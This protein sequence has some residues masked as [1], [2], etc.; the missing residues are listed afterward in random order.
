MKL[1]S[2]L[3]LFY[4]LTS[5]LFAQAVTDPYKNIKY[6]ELNNGLKVYMLSDEKAVNTQIDLEVNVGT[7]VETKENAGITHLLEH[8]IF[9][10]Q[11]VPY[12]DYLD[13]LKEE[14][15]GFVNGYTKEYSTEYIATMDSE[16]SYFL[17]KTL[18]QMI[19]D[20]NVT[21]ED[22]E[23]EKGAIQVE[24]GEV[25]WYH[26]IDYYISSFF[27]SLSSY[28]PDDPDVFVDSF[29]LEK[30][31]ESIPEYISKY[32]NSKFT[33]DEVMKH[34]EEYYYPKNMTLKIVGNF[35][36]DKMQK[37]IEEEYAN[38][39]RSGDKHSQEQAYNA[40]LKEE[41]YHFQLTG[42]SEKNMAY[43]GI[44]YL[45]DDYKQ[46]LT[47]SAYSYYL[48]NKM[49]KLLRNKLG[50][51]Y[52]VSL[53]ENSK[54][55]AGLLGVM[56]ESLHADFDQNLALI[57]KQLLADINGMESDTIKEALEQSRLCCNSLEH[58]SKTLMELLNTQEYLHKYY[59]IYDKTPYEI[60]NS[61]TPEYFQSEI[62]KSFADKY[63]YLYFYRDYYLFPFDVIAYS[64]LILGVIIIYF[65][66][67]SRLKLGT[68]E[69]LYTYRDVILRRRI[70]T[71]FVSIVI[72]VIIFILSNYINVWSE[73]YLSTLVFKNVNYMF[74]LSQSMFM[75][76]FILS[77][78]F[79]FAVF[80]LLSSTLFKRFFTKI[81][82]TNECLYVVGLSILAINKNEI[83][84]I[85]KVPWSIS[86]FFKIAGVSI[87][88]FKPLVKVE[89][90]SGKVIY[91]RAKKAG[92][93]AED[94]NKWLEK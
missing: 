71:H 13:Y 19:F 9:R 15:A 28:F 16:Q 94:L 6:L 46:Y 53:Y 93:L 82:L 24:V 87:F 4:L 51:T 29:E 69:V 31:K 92:E 50:Q 43:F 61:I 76:Y 81:E 36:E 54:R 86:K 38:I 70:T 10:D 25:K 37:L 74:T 78:L 45:L 60:F 21:S 7:S 59:K 80:I 12:N 47:L 27:Q 3:T 42:L 58:D 22:L 90:E 56:F 64:F 30:D 65:I 35:N 11:R 52:T 23:I 17:A 55:N 49:Q 2:L 8:L 1:T 77:S 67:A 79:F 14:G 48:S 73:Y 32:N 72:F 66:K 40:K 85:K 26:R 33:L 91:L 84:E 57:Q 18:A 63:R 83:V 44:R 5:T 89:Y 62:R 39:S 20:K 68:K 88:F 41:K 34:Y 75:L